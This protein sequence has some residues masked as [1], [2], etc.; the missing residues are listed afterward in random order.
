MYK[1]GFPAKFGGKLSS[2]LD[3]RLK[4]GD[5]NNFH[6]SYNIGLITSGISIEGPIQKQKSSFILS[7]R[8]FTLQP[9]IALFPQASRDNFFSGYG[10]YDTFLKVNTKIGKQDRLFVSFYLGNDNKKSNDAIEEQESYINWSNILGSIQWQRQWATNLFGNLSI[11]TSNY[12]TKNETVKYYTVSDNV[13]NYWAKDEN[14]INELG[15]KWGFDLWLKNIKIFYGADFIYNI[16]NPEISNSNTIT[17]DKNI[18]NENMYSKTADIYIGADYIFLKYFSINTGLRLN[19]LFS[20]NYMVTNPE[21]RVTFSVNISNNNSLKASYAVMHQN[22]HILSTSNLGVKNNWYI[23]ASE[24][25]PAQKSEQYAL[26]FYSANSNKYM[27][28]I[29]LFNKKFSNLCELKELVSLSDQNLSW[30]DKTEK[31][32]IGNSRGVEI[33]FNKNFS[34]INLGIAYTLSKST[35]KF[36][37]INN[38]FEYFSDFDRTHDLTVFINTK[39]GKKWSFNAAWYYMTGRPF[40]ME[41]AYLPYTYILDSSNRVWYYDKSYPQKNNIRPA[42]YHRL[43][44][45]FEKKIQKEKKRKTERIFNIGIYN[46]YNRTNPYYYYWNYTSI[47]HQ[48]YTFLDYKS[49]FPIIPYIS[50]SRSF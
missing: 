17:Q 34:F 32:G 25:L 40:T 31:G 9:F 7:A 50:Y 47:N 38:G 44:L 35:R 14:K 29:E 13:Y 33:Y 49:Y 1:S 36:E 45:S 10:F 22:S 41:T 6:Y 39:I 43:D 24:Y 46:A 4:D 27:F 19:T 3:I 48:T 2:V 37:N 5:L 11:Y 30:I 18:I 21:P 42:N 16:Y 28:S 12:K 23:P 20:E 8:G 15:I 26:G